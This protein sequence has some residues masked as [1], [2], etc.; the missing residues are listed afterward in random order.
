MDEKGIIKFC[1]NVDYE[2][3]EQFIIEMADVKL[4]YS[5]F[6]EGVKF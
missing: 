3:N 4:N 6:F 1:R 5:E 2:D